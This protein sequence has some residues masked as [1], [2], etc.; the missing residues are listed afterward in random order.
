MNAKLPCNHDNLDVLDA[1]MMMKLVVIVRHG[2]NIKISSCVLL[3]QK[4]VH[5]FD[6]FLSRDEQRNSLTNPIKAI[7]IAVNTP[8]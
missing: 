2:K 6:N 1:A 3:G 7:Y 5:K 8:R 4:K